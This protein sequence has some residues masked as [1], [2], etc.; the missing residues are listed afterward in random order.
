[1]VVA[2]SDGQDP[3]GFLYRPRTT[4]FLRLS[5][6]QCWD[7]SRQI[8]GDTQGNKRKRESDYY[9]LREH[10]EVCPG[11]VPKRLGA[12]DHVIDR[13]E[14]QHRDE[15]KKYRTKQSEQQP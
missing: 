1:M 10:E 13:Y 2:T 12:I 4:R 15:G 8:K 14:N 9:P 6:A 5:S 7:L 11:V 3:E